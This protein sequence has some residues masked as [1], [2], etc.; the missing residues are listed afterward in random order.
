MIRST[1]RNS[2]IET[3]EQIIS[4]DARV[5][6]YEA[7][8]KWFNF[9][10]RIC[11][12]LYLIPYSFDENGKLRIFSRR[13]LL[14]HYAVYAAAAL[15]ALHKFVV[16]CYRFSSA[17]S[18]LTDLS[19]FLCVISVLSYFVPFTI[20]V[21]VLFRKEE[22]ACVLNTW[23][24]LLA[25]LQPENEDGGV[26]CDTEAAFVLVSVSELCLVGGLGISML[27][28]MFESLPVSYFTAAEGLG[29]V[30]PTYMPNILWKLVLWPMELVTY[31][32][33]VLP[34]AWSHTINDMIAI[35]MKNCLSQMRLLI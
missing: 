30:N 25:S 32:M 21:S 4:R 28:F 16:L 9:I 31:M 1:Q 20:A 15:S 24:D 13:Q 17:D 5:W 22:T 23:N 19:T 11:S 27:G 8:S 18:T 14:I 6:F 10:G 33:P 26:F 2:L 12:K 34:C 35:I 3:V 7:T 29:L